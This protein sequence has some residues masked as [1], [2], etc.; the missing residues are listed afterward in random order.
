MRFACPAC[1]IDY[2]VAALLVGWGGAES[3]EQLDE[4]SGGADVVGYC[5]GVDVEPC[6]IV[7]GVDDLVDVCGGD[8]A[9][10]GG[11]HT[12]G[13]GFLVAVVVLV[14]PHVGVACGNHEGGGEVGGIAEADGAGGTVGV[15]E[16]DE[17]I[18]GIAAGGLGGTLDGGVG[19]A[20][21]R[22]EG[23]GGNTHDNDT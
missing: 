20:A 11:D 10:S 9:C 18:G 1:G 13:K 2:E 21:A 7:H 8:K 17:C 15:V 5:G 12:R 6:K 22:D 23:H 16:G 19:G 4:G 14:G 3:L